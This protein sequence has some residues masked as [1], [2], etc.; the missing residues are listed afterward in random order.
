M[1][2]RFVFLSV[3]LMVAASVSAAHSATT[4]STVTGCIF[5]N[6][7]SSGIGVQGTSSSGHGIDG[8]STTGFGVV[9]TT[10]ENSTSTSNAKA[11]VE[12]IDSSTNSTKFNSGVYGSSSHGHGVD[13]ETSDGIGVRGA[14]T[15]ADGNGIGVL[16]VSTFSQY[17]YHSGGTGV[18]GDSYYGTG[19]VGI[20]HACC[21]ATHNPM[22][23]DVP[24]GVYGGGTHG[25]M[26]IAGGG[27][28]DV[29]AGVIGEA[30]GSIGDN[31]LT[32]L[33]GYTAVGS[34]LFQGL[35]PDPKGLYEYVVVADIDY[36][37]NEV[38]AGTLTTHGSP[39]IV[40]RSAIGP[41]VASYSA[42]TASPT[43]ED[44][45][46][47]TL[48]QGTAYV[49][50]DPTFASTIDRTN[51]TVFVTPEGDSRGL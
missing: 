8:S 42:R 45:G 6:N 9:G 40:T 11:G 16:G 36:K 28:P 34:D 15:A 14:T 25:V 27:Y 43:L 30:N 1:N 4:C 22:I 24:V 47:A 18:E 48:R 31:R 37:G 12:G 51:Y 13:G 2:F 32:A 46:K 33:A 17:P 41:D 49:A 21:G 10:H 38:L 35:S 39:Y 20:K 44:V 7:T 19:V 5:G 50:L 23:N 3:P 26:G 29:S